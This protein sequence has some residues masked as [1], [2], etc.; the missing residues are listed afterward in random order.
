[1]SESRLSLAISSGVI[2]LPEHGDIVV[3]CPPK[4]YDLSALPRARVLVVQGFKPDHDAFAA[5][6][7]AVTTTAPVQSA[8]SIVVVPRAK[9]QGLHLLAEAAMR[10]PVVIDGLKSHGVESVLKAVKTRAQIPPP[11]SKAHAK[12]APIPARPD[13]LAGS[14]RAPTR[15]AGGRPAAPGAPPP[16]APS[17]RP[18][19]PPRGP[20][21]KA[22]PFR[23][24][25]TD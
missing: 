12:L 1:M 15:L 10:G 9:S 25:Q 22:E 19:P 7:Y 23:G 5:A 2:D 11:V 14:R 20:R 8:L 17:P 16:R 4:G 24:A 18:V 21:T 13:Q 3:L 6:G